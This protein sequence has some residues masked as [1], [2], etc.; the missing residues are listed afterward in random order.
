MTCNIQNYCPNDNIDIKIE[1]NGYYNC[2]IKYNTIYINILNDIQTSTLNAGYIV[3]ESC[4]ND[5]YKFRIQNNILSGLNLDIS[6]QFKL[7]IAQFENDVSCSINPTNKIIN[8][9]VN[10]NNDNCKNIYM[11]IKIDNIIGDNYILIGDNILHLYGFENIETITVEAGD[12]NK[13]NCNNNIYEFTFIDSKIYNEI[14]NN[15]EIEFS[16]QLIK[17][18]I[19]YPKC[20]LPSNLKMNDIFNITCKII[21]TNNCPITGDKELLF[22]KNPGIIIYDSKRTINFKS[23][24]GKSTIINI[25]AGRLSKLEFDEL[26]KIYSIIFSNSKFEYTFNID[27]LFNIKLNINESEKSINCN[28]EK[29]SKDIICE[30]DNIE[31]DKI[32]ILVL[33]NPIDDFESLESKTIIFTDFIG[34]QINTIA[35]GKIERGKCVGKNY[36]FTFKNSTIPIYTENKFYLQM[37]YPN[38]EAICNIT[39]NSEVNEITCVIE[40]ISTCIVESEDS[41][42]IV[43]ELEP[44]PIEIDDNIIL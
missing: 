27:I 15:K 40:G 39:S 28:L 8:C 30:L 36:I 21:G 6:G 17:P 4:N 25:S 16:L 35:A 31:S 18:E 41:D 3:K 12:L 10:E 19:L 24:A 14:L 5:L 32:N 38:K 22:D 26:K 2:D 34:K 23:F 7:K 44:E 43:G 20:Y 42:I 13:G 37:K 29:G 11:D 1:K 33:E 9:N